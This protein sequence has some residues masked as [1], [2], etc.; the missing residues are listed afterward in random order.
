MPK[1]QDPGTSYVG[2]MS[3]TSMDGIDAVLVEFGDH[4][5]EIRSTL[6][7]QYP[8]ELRSALLK[9]SRTPAECTVD[10]IGKLDH[11]IGE[12]FRDATLALLKENGVAAGEVV[13]IG[14]H[15]Q[16]LRYHRDR[17]RHHDGCRF[18]AC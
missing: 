18:P 10:L 12:C 4:R 7:A 11:W 3:G 15:G 6:S 2:L 14:S 13:A 9:A 17:H 16:T 8:E 1:H 5:C